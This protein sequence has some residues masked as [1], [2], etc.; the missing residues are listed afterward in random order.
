M[1]VQT[2]FPGVPQAPLEIS[3]G[4]INPVWLQFFLNLF[5][6]TG[7]AAGT[8]SVQLDGI[9]DQVGS[10]LTRGPAAWQGLPPAEVF[11]VLR[12]GA[13][14]PIWDFLSGDSFGDKARN[15][16]LAGP[17]AGADAPPGFRQIVTEDL[18]AGQLPATNTND[19]ADPDN[20]GAYLDGTDTTVMASGTIADVVSINLDPGDWDVWGNLETNPGGATTQSDILGWISDAS[21]TDPGFPNGGAYARLQ[22]AAASGDDQIIPVGMRRFSLSVTTP[23]FLSSKITFAAGGLS[24][25]GFLAARRPR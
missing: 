21:A 17:T 25:A 11:K 8:V 19:N 12:M 3:P 22:M 15:Q 13:V 18:P 5:N 20:V 23:I 10:I 1:D 14:L 2:G 16:F 9:S 7:G 6:R 4:V 24:A